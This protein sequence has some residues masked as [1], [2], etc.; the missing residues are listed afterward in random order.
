MA[1]ETEKHRN[2]SEAEKTTES[3]TQ[4][5]EK[6]SDTKK[7]PNMLIN[8]CSGSTTEVHAESEEKYVFIMII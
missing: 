7:S 8:I 3:Q 5:I 4:K 6:D 2:K 1:R